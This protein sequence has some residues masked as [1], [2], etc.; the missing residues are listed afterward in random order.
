MELGT[1]SCNYPQLLMV[2]MKD[3]KKKRTHFLKA[4]RLTL[5]M[6]ISKFVHV[7]LVYVSTVCISFMSTT[8]T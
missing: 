7:G 2:I 4:K 5:I 8:N 1:F 3:V 6:Y